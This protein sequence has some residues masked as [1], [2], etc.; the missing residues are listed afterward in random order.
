M[1]K[2]YDSL[3]VQHS[4]ANNNVD[5]RLIPIDILVMHDGVNYNSSSFSKEAMESAKE[6]LKNIP[7]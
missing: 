1:G 5:D 4:I 6:S 2:Q 3:K 7:I